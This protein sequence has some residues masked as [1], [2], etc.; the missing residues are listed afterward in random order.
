MTIPPDPAFLDNLIATLAAAW[1]DGSAEE[2]HSAARSALEALQPRDIIEAMLGVRMIA[3]HHAA[4][5]GYRRAMQPGIG[6]AEAVRLRN[7]AVSA[8]RSF[9]TALRTL[10]KRRAPAPAARPAEKPARSHPA[11]A[12]PEAES[13]SENLVIPHRRQFVPRDR[14]GNPIPLWRF[15]DMTMAQRRATYGDPDD[16]DSQAAAIAEEEA[17]IEVARRGA[18]GLNGGGETGGS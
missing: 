8:G 7:N 11:A 10:E 4:M 15:E 1:P 9:D 16:V 18:A 14:T 12:K 3:A 13:P 17:M 6:D 5:D 2:R